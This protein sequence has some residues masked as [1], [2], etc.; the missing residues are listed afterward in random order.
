MLLI[1]SH[2]HL[3]SANDRTAIVATK[4]LETQLIENKISRAIVSCSYC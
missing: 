2:L 4:E 1:D 3:D